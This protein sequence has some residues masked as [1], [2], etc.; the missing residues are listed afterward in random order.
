MLKAKLWWGWAVET[1]KELQQCPRQVETGWR[2]S[3]RKRQIENSAVQ[4]VTHSQTF[5]Y[6]ASVQGKLTLQRWKHFCCGWNKVR[7]LLPAPVSCLTRRNADSLVSWH[8]EREC[9]RSVR[10]VRFW[11]VS[12]SFVKGIITASSCTPHYLINSHFNV[13]SL[14]NNVCFRLNCA[15]PKAS[16]TVITGLWG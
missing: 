16:G 11:G 7:R 2:E 14:I 4:R 15:L 6:S 9:V 3:E 8:V 13:K 1:N 10:R 5:I 12:V